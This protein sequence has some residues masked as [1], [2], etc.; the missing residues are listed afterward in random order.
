MQRV[1]IGASGLEILDRVYF[2][3][4]RDTI[5]R[6]SFPLLMNVAQVLNNHPEITR[7]Q[8]EGHTDSR[9]R[10]EH[11]MSL[12]QRR[13]QAVVDF[14]VERGSVDASRLVARGFGPDRPVV[15]DA[16][17][18]EEHAQNRRVEF[19]IPDGTGIEQQDNEAP[20]EAADR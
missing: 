9:G 2:R 1:V 3:T 18:A 20:A 13:A 19:N 14:L 11:N 12:S 6:R 8:V 17:T 10:R 15:E 4:N 16:S 5:L 7:I